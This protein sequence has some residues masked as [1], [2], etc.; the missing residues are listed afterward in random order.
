MYRSQLASAEGRRIRQPCEV[1]PGMREPFQAQAGRGIARESELT[2][3]R[4]LKHATR[5][6]RCFIGAAKGH[7]RAR[8]AEA[9]RMWR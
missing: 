6:F 4:S 2:I 3:Y 9:P 5:Q 7:V 1:A 8:L